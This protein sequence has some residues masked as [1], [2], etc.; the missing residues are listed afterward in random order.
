MSIDGMTFNPYG[1]VTAG[2]RAGGQAAINPANG[3]Q[4]FSADG[5]G[6]QG[7]DQ[8]G[9]I[10]DPFQTTQYFEKDKQRRT[11]QGGNQDQGSTVNPNSDIL[12]QQ[13]QQKENEKLR[14]QDLVPQVNGAN[15]AGANPFQLDLNAIDVQL[16]SMQ[17]QQSAINTSTQSGGFVGSSNYE[18]N[19]FRKK[20]NVLV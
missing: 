16:A 1:N 9:A 8:T 5:G 10:S 4:A 17:N 3:L 19:V 11:A 13:I 20:L 6:P 15:P 14:L 12:Q 2:I 18:S 7:V